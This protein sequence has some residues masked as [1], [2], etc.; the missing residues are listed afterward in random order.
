MNIDLSINLK[1]LLNSSSGI[2]FEKTGTFEVN[3]DSFQIR[4]EDE[5]SIFCSVKLKDEYIHFECDAKMNFF[6]SCRRCLSEN[7]AFKEFKIDEHFNVYQDNDFDIEVLDEC[8]DLSTILSESIIENFGETYICNPDCKGLC[9]ECG[10]NLNE[11]SCN[12][13]KKNLKESPFS[14][15]SQ[16]DL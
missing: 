10:L 15:L 3:Y 7:S 11:D 4:P 1:D 13:E 9:S 16:L 6:Q 14:S 5:V 2:N 12:H 8:I